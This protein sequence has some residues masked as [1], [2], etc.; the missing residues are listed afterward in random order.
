[1]IDGYRQVFPC[2][3]TGDQYI[4]ENGVWWFEHVGGTRYRTNNPFN[5]YEP[6]PPDPDQIVVEASKPPTCPASVR[7]SYKEPLKK[8]FPKARTSC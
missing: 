7:N 5:H 6:Q 8:I 1:M 2:S 3:T 4:L